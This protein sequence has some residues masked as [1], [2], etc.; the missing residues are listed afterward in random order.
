MTLVAYLI[1]ASSLLGIS[2][3]VFRVIVKRAYLRRGCL[4]VAAGLL[5]VFVWAMFFLFPYLY[6]PPDW[7]WFLAH[8]HPVGPSTLATALVLL[9]VGL[10]VIV[11]A[12]AQ[13][14][15]PRVSGARSTTLQENGLYRTTRNPQIVAGV[16]LVVGSALL[17]PSWYAGGWV[18]IYCAM[19]HMMV[20]AEEAHLGNRHGPLYARYRER[21]PR[22]LGIRGPRNLKKKDRRKTG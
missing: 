7:A 19:A 13:L 22:Y 12:M 11:I 15:L 4:G 1:A 6:N 8:A 5:Q 17:W 16:P 9:T 2:F 14:G 18:A 21:V 3:A 10:V 20:L